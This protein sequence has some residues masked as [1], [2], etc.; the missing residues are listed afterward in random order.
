[1][2][3]TREIESRVLRSLENAP[4]VAILGPRQCGKSTL[5]RHLISGDDSQIGLSD[6][7]YLDLERP[8]DVAKLADAEAFFNANADHL[9]C[10]DEIQRRPDLFPVLR[11][12]SDTIGKNGQF[13]I[14]G[15]ASPDLLRQ[16]SETL[17]GRIAFHELT[18]F[19]LREVASEFELETIL[20]RGGFPRSL[21]ARSDDASL[22]WRTNFIKTYLERDLGQYDLNIPVTLVSR[23]WRMLAHY[24]GQ[25]INYSQLSNSLGVSGP[26]VKKYTD[27]LSGTFMVR[28]LEP[29]HGNLKKRLT[30]TPR[31]YI[32]DTGILLSLLGVASYNDLLGHPVYGSLW[33]SFVIENIIQAFPT[34]D[35][36]F[37]RT[38]HGAEIDLVM[39]TPR[40]SIAIECKASTAPRLQKG[41]Y[42]ACED[43][44]ALLRLV[45]AP[46]DTTWPLS[47]GVEVHS[48]LSAIMR[49]EEFIF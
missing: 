14:T 34:F 45:I 13:L 26:T 15:S 10:L 47:E 42:S 33:E 39:Q 18:P 37:F 5:L 22:E 19:Q 38:S 30:R 4:I 43:I 36:T 1:M 17:A 44:N 46:V 11:A 7:I 29:Y 12:H 20:V 48:L 6:A 49:M 32:R 3:I 40:G 8:S 9:I 27:L 16:G 28:L 31:V 2:I 41:F 25:L 21:L 24:H 35:H 23:L